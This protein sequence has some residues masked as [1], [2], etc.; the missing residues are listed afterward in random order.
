MSEIRLKRAYEPADPTDGI[1]VLVDRL[2]PRGIKKSE[3]AIDVWLKDVAPSSALRQW[4]GHDPAKWNEFQKR[5]RAEL[6][7]NAALQEL[8]EVVAHNKRITLVFGARDPDHNNAVVLSE[9]C[10]KR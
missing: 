8:R 1:R 2:W 9:V 4:F 3:A 5:Y 6:S 10:G 7:H